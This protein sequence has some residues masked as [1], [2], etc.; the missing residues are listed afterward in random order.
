MKRLSI[1]L[2][3]VNL[4]SWVDGVGRFSRQLIEGYGRYAK[5]HEFIVF[6]DKKASESFKDLPKNV[7]PIYCDVRQGKYIPRNQLYFMARYLR[8]PGL[9]LLH[10]PVSV[11]PFIGYKRAKCVVTLH[12]VAFKSHPESVGRTQKIWQ[13]T[14]WPICLRRVDHVVASSYATKA[15]II[16]YYKIPS[17]KISVIHL[18]VNISAP[19]RNQ[20]ADDMKCRNAIS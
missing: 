6:I 1:G 2:D 19:I 16:K 11:A 8:L 3:L 10:S 12:D 20:K 14:A 15:D 5:N 18:C 9:D 13:K 7:R 4:R 17:L